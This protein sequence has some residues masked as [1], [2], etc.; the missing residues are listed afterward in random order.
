MVLIDIKRSSLEVF[1][2]FRCSA[3]SVKRR[4]ANS[5]DIGF[6]SFYWWWGISVGVVSLSSL[7]LKG[8]HACD[9]RLIVLSE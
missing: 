8:K 9:F 4:W 1:D 2:P 7:Y 5:V 6:G 3:E